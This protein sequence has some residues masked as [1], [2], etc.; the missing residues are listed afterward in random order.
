MIQACFD[1]WFSLGIHLDLRRRRNAEQQIDFGPYVDLHLGCVI[2]SLGYNPAVSG[3][4]H[5]SIN[6]GRGGIPE[7]Y[8][9]Q[10]DRTR[11]IS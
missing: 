3:R 7:E 9:D 2:I 5:S 6:C 4:L 1:G 8:I 10:A 11:L